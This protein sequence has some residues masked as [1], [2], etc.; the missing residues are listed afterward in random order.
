MRITILVG[1]KFHAFDLAQQL[2]AKGHLLKLITTYPKWKVTKNYDIP[3]EKIITFFFKELVER[4]IYKFRLS[5]FLY[6]LFKHLNKYFENFA[7]KSI[8]YKNTDIIIG[9]SGFSYKTFIKAKAYKIIKICERGSTHIKFQKEIL[10]EEYKKFN[11]KF[12]FN[13]EEIEKEIKEY[14]LADYISVPSNF[15]KKTFLENGVEE[16]KIITT[17]YGVDLSIFKN[18]P[19]TDKIFRFISVGRIGLRKGSFYT[20]K[21]FDELKI[22]NCELLMIGSIED[23][24]ATI[25]N[26]FKNNINIIFIN[27]VDQKLL[28]KFYNQSDVF[29]ISSIEDG[30]AMVILQALASGLPV[31]CTQNS[32]G[33]EEIIDGE[34]G[35]IL[36]PRNIKI[37]KEK[38]IFFLN[39]ENLVNLKKKVGKII[40][41]LSWKKYGDAIENKLKDLLKNN[42]HN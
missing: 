22:P 38:M 10:Q 21:A 6:F 32:G 33:S 19:K 28:T 2:E 18:R 31:I 5:K 8:D 17:P 23:E 4:L 27:H 14:N 15:S 42:F 29:I 34:N 37:L 9:W 11:I 24:F 26:Q 35:F 40:S 25:A 3:K 20:L 36:E 13:E 30:F 12:K 16:R 1:G 41:N 7:S 39:P